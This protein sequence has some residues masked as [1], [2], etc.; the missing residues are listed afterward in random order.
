VGT[1][2]STGFEAQEGGGMKTNA[3]L[4]AE[5]AEMDRRREQID[6]AALLFEVSEFLGRFIAYPSEHAQI[7]YTLWI[8]HAHMMDAWDS[9]PR[10]AFLSPEPGSGKT[11]AL[12]IS[13]L[14]V[15]NALQNVNMTSAYLF[16]RIGA[17]IG[18]PTLLIDEVDALFSG[19][20]QNM[21][22][23]RGLL[24]AGHR[25]GAMVGRCV[26]HGKT[27]TT[28]ESPAFCAVALAG[29]GWLP[30]TLMSRSIIIRMRRRAPQEKIEPFRRRDE[31]VRG[32]A[33]RDR[34][35]KWAAP[36]IDE[37]K[38]ARPELPAGVE[39]RAADCWEPLLAIADAA[40]GNKWPDIA[41]RAAV[42]L[43]TAARDANPSL[44]ILLLEHCRTA[45][46][47]LDRLPSEQLLLR[48][49]DLPE[50]PWRNMKG[51][52]L[53]DRGLAVRLKR[54]EIKPKVIRFG[55]STARGYLRADFED[56]WPRYLAAP[57]QQEAQHA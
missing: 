54:Y 10:L 6:G 4:D 49:H 45:F 2:L 15:P 22:E 31:L 47:D 19:K 8:A 1:Q 37:I 53:D 12:E 32:E 38:R 23:I 3:A 35:S 36:L 9:T 39:D 34:L 30:D 29:L 27:V 18:L 13:E 17:E 40:G 55:Q 52:P 25:R 33:L 11:R 41:R 56:V 14:L 28:E 50:S 24:N 43:V 44:G 26:I 20:S 48:L 46:G 16:R 7:G 5:I 57:S 42:E 21:E 51:K